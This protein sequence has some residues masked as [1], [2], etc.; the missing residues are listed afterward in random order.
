M[1]TLILAEAELERIPHEIASHPAVMLYAKQKKKEPTTLLLDSNYH[2]AAMGA[3][4]EGR[5]R[6]RPDITHLVL[7]TALESIANKRGELR[8][9]IHTRND[10]VITVAPQTRIMRSY[11][12]FTGLMEQLFRQ[13]AVPDQLR[14]LLSLHR[15]TLAEL[16]PTLRADHIVV[17]SP[18]GRPVDIST[19]FTELHKTGKKE[20]VAVVGGFPS[21]EFRTDLSALAS[22]RISL[23]PEMLVAWTVASELL[24]SFEHGLRQAS[25]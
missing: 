18:A 2:H 1:L 7:L 13:G 14:P 21:G 5:R 11:E 16:L 20:I 10:E 9:L 24:V 23:F 19:Y 22:D 25:P 6:G 8:I 15:Q 4:P 12:R 17:C 3:L